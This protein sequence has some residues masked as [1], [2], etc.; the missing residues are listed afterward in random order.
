MGGREG[1]LG[2]CEIF[3]T[4]FVALFSMGKPKIEKSIRKQFD[5]K[6][7]ANREIYSLHGTQV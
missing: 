7:F 1:H 3:S 4:N 6:S 2:I 5:G